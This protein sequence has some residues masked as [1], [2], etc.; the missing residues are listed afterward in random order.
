MRMHYI[1]RKIWT[2]NV[3]V[4]IDCQIKL[5]GGISTI[6]FIIFICVSIIRFNEICGILCS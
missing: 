3:K 4:T 2:K 1:Y 6:W 5:T